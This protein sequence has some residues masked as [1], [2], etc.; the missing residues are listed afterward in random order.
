M[1]KVVL[2]TDI[3]GRA[4]QSLTPSATSVNA[5]IGGTSVRIA[6]PAASV[7]RVS[8]SGDCYLEFGDVTVVAASTDMLFPTGVEIFSLNPSWTHVAVIQV[9]TST[10]VLSVTEMN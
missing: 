1:S 9:G 7:I 6:L 5:T 8:A 3:N 4:L 10:G 2:K